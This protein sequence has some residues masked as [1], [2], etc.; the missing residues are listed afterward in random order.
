VELLGTT[1][2]IVPSRQAA[3]QQDPGIAP[4]GRPADDIPERAVGLL[5]LSLGDPR[6][7]DLEIRSRTTVPGPPEIQ[8]DETR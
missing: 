7:D 8:S 1:T 2:V 6:S 4:E 5:G 3:G